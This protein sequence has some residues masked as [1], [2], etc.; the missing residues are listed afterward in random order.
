MEPLPTIQSDSHHSSRLLNFAAAISWVT[1][2]F[3]GVLDYFNTS[4]LSF[5]ILFFGAQLAFGL[6]FLFQRLGMFAHARFVLLFSVNVFCFVAGSTTPYD[7]GGRF[8]YL[9]I[10]LMAITLHNPEEKKILAFHL[11]NSIVCFALSFWIRLPSYHSMDAAM[12]DPWTSRMVNYIG[13]YVCTISLAFIF[14]RHIVRLRV[15][16]A[17]QSKFS[18][19]GM[20]AAGV[21]HEINNPLAIITGRAVL[22][23]KKLQQGDSEAANKSFEQIIGTAERIG[24]IVR[25]LKHISRDGSLDDFQNVKMSTVIQSTLDLCS[26]RFRISGVQLSVGSYVDFELLG[27]EA[28]LVQ[29][30]VNLL[31]NAHDAIQDQ[32]EKWV[33]IEIK[34][35]TVSVLDSGPGIPEHLRDK[36]M[37]PFFTTKAPSKGTG[38]GLSI[39]SGIIEKH[40]GVLRLNTQSPNTCFEMTFGR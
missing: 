13:V 27:S 17:E 14:V 2:T 10:S 9:P 32:S 4:Y 18:A 12:V 26:E 16:A 37:E 3:F 39:S 19:L 23:I 7:D 20:M 30:L 33:R 29:V 21:A 6:L 11:F 15:A 8:F 1:V 25:G 35:R 36:L 38:L 28:Q 40:G 5:Q 24:K 34:D 22:G 31:N